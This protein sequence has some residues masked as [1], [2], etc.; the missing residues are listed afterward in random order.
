VNVLCNARVRAAI[1][2]LGIRLCGANAITD[3]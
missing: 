3:Q 2:S 1:T